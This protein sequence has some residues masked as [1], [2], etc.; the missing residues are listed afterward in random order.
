MRGK[1]LAL[2]EG[3]IPSDVV[4]TSI[5]LDNTIS[6]T[7]GPEEH[8]V[9]DQQ[10]RHSDEDEDEDEDDEQVEG[11]IVE[12]EKTPDVNMDDLMMNLVQQS[13]EH[14]STSS[15]NRTDVIVSGR[16]IVEVER[17]KLLDDDYGDAIYGDNGDE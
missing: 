12:D 15:L 3:R 17:T 16:Q 1:L 8:V 11:E 6:T 14:L 9:P 13:A 4:F 7:S 10:E 5:L 2:R